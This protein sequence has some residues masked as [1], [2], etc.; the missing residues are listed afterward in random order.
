L[1]SG[2]YSLYTRWDTVVAQSPTVPL[3]GYSETSVSYWIQRGDDS[4][5]EDP[6][7][8]EDLVVE[9][10]NN[11]A[12]WVILDTFTG[13]GTPGEIF[14]AWHNLP[15]DA[16]HD[17]FQIR[18]GQ[19]DGSGSDFDYWHI[20]DVCVYDGSVIEQVVVSLPPV[21]SVDT[22]DDDQVDIIGTMSSGTGSEPVAD[23]VP[24]VE[25]TTMQDI[26]PAEEVEDTNTE[27][28]PGT[29]AKLEPQTEL[30]GTET[31]TGEITGAVDNIPA[32]NESGNG[33]VSPV[34]IIFMAVSMLAIAGYFH[35][36]R[37]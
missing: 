2:I 14:H 26:A 10:L 33:T 30:T 3:G 9:Y 24:P 37:K 16:L 34:W 35:K 19:L 6:D 28:T 18:F 4:F 15:A 21:H 36:K 5:S 20:D 23:I 29:S 27:Q 12:V 7:P 1:N 31:S 8:G 11:G 32:I 22:T 17:N 13:S 25:E